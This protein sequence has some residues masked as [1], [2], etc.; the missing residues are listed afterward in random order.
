MENVLS[1][2]YLH[3]QKSKRHPH[4]PNLRKSPKRRTISQWTKYPP[5]VLK[6]CVSVF[7][8]GGG[9]CFQSSWVLKG[10]KSKDNKLNFCDVVRW[11]WTFQIAI[12]L[13]NVQNRKKNT[14][15]NSGKWQGSKFV[16]TQNLDG[17]IE[18]WAW[19]F[20]ILEFSSDRMKFLFPPPIWS[21]NVLAEKAR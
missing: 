13:V 4:R 15:T 1:S 21:R 12:H 8:S 9:D 11:N 6:E 16:L 5:A 14:P 20:V 10:V 19:E 2:T 18:S 17:S 3:L 7:G